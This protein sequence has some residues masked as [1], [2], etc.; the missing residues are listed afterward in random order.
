M[1]GEAWVM[2]GGEDERFDCG[3]MFAAGGLACCAWR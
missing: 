3:E 2:A 1:L